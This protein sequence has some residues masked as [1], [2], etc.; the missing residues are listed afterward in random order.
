MF[1]TSFLSDHFIQM[2]LLASLFASLSSGTMGSFVV[3]KRIVF[4]AG[5]ISHSILA[6]TSFCLWLQRSQGLSFPTPIEGAFAA[7]IGSAL[8]LGWIHLNYRQREDA[9]IAAIWSTGMAIGVIFL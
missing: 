8:L 3:V 1:L 6:G 5:S 7:A 2:A 9:V 4:I